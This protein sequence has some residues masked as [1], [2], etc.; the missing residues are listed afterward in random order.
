MPIL[1]MVHS[2][3][4]TER[5]KKKKKTSI[6]KHQLFRGKKK[7]PREWKPPAELWN[8]NPFPNMMGVWARIKIKIKITS[9]SR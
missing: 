8:G 9:G 2:H 6:E 1:P 3:T 7:L 5:E 4:V